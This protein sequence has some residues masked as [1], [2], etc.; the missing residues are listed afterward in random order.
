MTVDGRQ[1]AGEDPVLMLGI[2][3]GVTIGGGTPL[4][5]GPGPTTAWWTSSSR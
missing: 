4:T 1:M 5:P 3:N 2:G